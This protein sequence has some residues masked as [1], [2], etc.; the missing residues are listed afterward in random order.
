MGRRI[1]LM[2]RL[3]PGKTVTIAAWH[4]CHTAPGGVIMIERED[5]GERDSTVK[6]CPRRKGFYRR[7]Q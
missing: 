3:L 7:T 5:R 4:G 2:H 1:V 6:G